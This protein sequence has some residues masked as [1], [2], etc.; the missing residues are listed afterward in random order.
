M[1]QQAVA[2]AEEI[3]LDALSLCPPHEVASTT[4]VPY[5]HVAL[6]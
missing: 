3:Y 1:M 2:M 6:T 5:Y 4:S